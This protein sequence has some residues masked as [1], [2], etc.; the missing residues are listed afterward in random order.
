MP[1]AKAH[2]AGW[3]KFMDAAHPKH[4]KRAI[5]TIAG[6]YA[7]EGW[8][9]TQCRWAAW[10]DGPRTKLLDAIKREWAK[11]S[12][13]PFADFPYEDGYAAISWLMYLHQP[14]F[15]NPAPALPS[16]SVLTAKNWRAGNLRHAKNSRHLGPGDSRTS[17]HKS[18]TWDEPG[19]PKGMRQSRR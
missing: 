16:G 4:L 10:T 7:A 3:A 1:T 15:L 13:L 19:I 14:Q 2:G 12:G 6:N 11:R 9:P 8:T 5:S 17:P 18:G